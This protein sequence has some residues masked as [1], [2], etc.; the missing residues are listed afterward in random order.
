MEGMSPQQTRRMM[1]AAH[2][3]IITQTGRV[4][5]RLAAVDSRSGGSAFWD[6]ASSAISVLRTLKMGPWNCKSGPV[7]F[8]QDGGGL[9]GST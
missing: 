4:W 8:P 2:G 9:N 6:G 3:Q 1:V 7:G 5:I